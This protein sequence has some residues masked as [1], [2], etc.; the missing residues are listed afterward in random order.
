MSKV[1]IV[2]DNSPLLKACAAEN[3]EVY[4]SALG[5]FAHEEAPFRLDNEYEDW[6]EGKSEDEQAA[7]ISRVES[8]IR[9]YMLEDER[10]INYDGLDEVVDD[11]M[12]STGY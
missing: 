12:E 8:A 1:I 11:A 3:V 7:I 6:R 5:A 10:A 2:E 9:F 4:D